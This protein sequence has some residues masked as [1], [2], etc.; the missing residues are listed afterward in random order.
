MPS[1]VFPRNRTRR[2]PSPTINL[3]LPQYHPGQLRAREAIRHNRFVVAILGR[4]WGKTFLGV[5]EMAELALLQ[6]GSMQMWVAPTHDLAT[7]AREEFH[8]LFQPVIAEWREAERRATL[9][10]GSRVYWR[11]ADNPDSLIGR[12][13]DRVIV[14]EAAR[15]SDDAYKRA[16][17]PT[18]ADRKG[19]LLAITTPKGRRGWVYEL[20]RRALE[21]KKGYALIKGASTENPNP[22]IKRY[23]EEMRQTMPADIFAQEFLADPQD[24]AGSYFRNVDECIEG[25]VLETGRPDALYSLG[26]D[27]AKYEDFTVLTA[28]NY[29][30]MQVEGFERFHRLDWGTQM[31]RITDFWNRMQQGSLT[32]DSTGIGDAIYDG[33][34]ERGVSVSPFK[35]DN[36]S[37][38]R[39]C[40]QLSSAIEQKSIRYPEIP[41]LIEELKRFQYEILPSGAVR[42]GAPAGAHD[43]C[44]ISLALAL[45]G[46]L[47]SHL[48]LLQYMRDEAARISAS[49][50]DFPKPSWRHGER[51]PYPDRR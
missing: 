18:L 36:A 4:R 26:A 10:G 47:Q 14:D 12:G 19:S 1:P 40:L 28:I 2:F 31:S 15:V 35:F 23:V 42:L 34:R 3:N 33:L 37:K 9:I 13:F 25:E 22:E 46:C 49:Q 21:G 16:I 41:V 27:V 30:T 6:P 45:H 39:L 38:T 17:L 7:I 51:P 44:V 5:N 24:E 32:I 29:E 20:Y 48:G 11:S 43:D 50:E 8:R